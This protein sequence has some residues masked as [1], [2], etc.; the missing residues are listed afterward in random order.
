MADPSD[1][2]DTQVLSDPN[3]RTLVNRAAV[4]A[5]LISDGLRMDPSQLRSS[6]ER[7]TGAELLSQHAAG[8]FDGK[9][10]RCRKVGK[11]RPSSSRTAIGPLEVLDRVFGDFVHQR[12]PDR[13][14]LGVL[15]LG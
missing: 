7:L 15:Q 14:A 6:F 2:L 5:A 11:P 3:T 9:F 1:D 12:G 10:P 8:A 13:F 4:P